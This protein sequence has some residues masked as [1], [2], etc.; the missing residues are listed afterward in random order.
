MAGVHECKIP[1][2]RQVVV[3]VGA[4]HVRRTYVCNEESKKTCDGLSGAPLSPSVEPFA[5]TAPWMLG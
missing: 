1:K 4:Y 3:V 2:R 5:H